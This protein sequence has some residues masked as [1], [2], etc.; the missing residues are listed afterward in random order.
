MEKKALGK[1]LGAIF[2]DNTKAAVTA[3][4]TAGVSRE[5]TKLRMSLIEPNRSQPRKNFEKESLEELADSIR[6]FGVLQPIL[7]RKT[8]ATFEIVAGERRWRAARLAGLKEIP[9]IVKDFS[10][11][12]AAEIA[13]IENIQ[14]EDLNPLEEARAYRTLM[15]EFGLTQEEIAGRVSRSRPSIANALRLLQLDESVQKLLETGELTAGH[16][17]ALVTL[18]SPLQKQAAEQIVGN[19]LSVRE[20]EALLKKMQDPGTAKKKADRKKKDGTELYLQELSK[21][22]TASLGS[23]VTVSPMNR[24]K[25]RVEIEYYSD[26]DLEK[27]LERL[28]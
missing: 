14:R 4:V 23:K 25:G 1:G 13:I 24:G 18:P 3:E 20:T 10:E 19:S 22:L 11:K 28:G 17:R 7:V 15:E 6:Q 8:G 26:N 12:E 27:L 5:T 21:K 2:S 16:A 9:A